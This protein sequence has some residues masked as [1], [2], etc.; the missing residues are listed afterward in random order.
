MSSNSIYTGNKYGLDK[1]VWRILIAAVILPAGLLSYRLNVKK[2]CIPVQYTIKSLSADTGNIFLTG[3][4][5]FF[6][7]SS[8]DREINWNFGE[9]DGKPAAGQYV[10]YTY[11][12]EGE[13][14]VSAGSGLGCENIKKIV[15]KKA[16]ADSI[17]GTI[18]GNI[19]G[20]G[21]TITGKETSY[22]FS[23]SA[24]DYEWVVL[25]YPKYTQK[26]PGATFTFSDKGTYTLQLTLD[27][28]HSKRVTKNIK[29]DKIS[30]GNSEGSTPPPSSACIST[31]ISDA[32]FMQLMQKVVSG[33]F[34]VNN[35]KPYLSSGGGTPVIVNGKKENKNFA[36]ACE[37]L[38]GKRKS[39][40]LLWKKK[41]SISGIKLTR[42]SNNCVTLIEINYN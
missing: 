14:F 7:A 19:V 33:E 28:D 31:F 3:E 13:Y 10:F 2:E 11:T 40:N 24:K 23:G 21:I 25:N 30:T 41:I 42:D 27:N 9:K 18:T 4:T 6:V 8:N 38:N 5:I 35:F 26:G 17:P 1:S 29:V 22:S 12:N 32:A 16:V 20:P 36:W 37:Y 15:I 34:N 39:H